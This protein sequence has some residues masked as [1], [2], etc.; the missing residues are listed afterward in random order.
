MD[1]A[2]VWF[3]F[4]CVFIAISH[5]DL[6]VE[7]QIYK[8]NHGQEVVSYLLYVNGTRMNTCTAGL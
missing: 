7:T 6:V 4:S 1:P 5:I 8:Y 2:F 3:I